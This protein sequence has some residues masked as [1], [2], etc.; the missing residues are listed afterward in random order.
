MGAK[1]TNEQQTPENH[2]IDIDLGGIPIRISNHTGADGSWKGLQLGLH[3][4]GLMV[5]DLD[6][7][8]AEMNPTDAEFIVEP[9]STRPGSRI[10]FVL[11]PDGVLM[12][13]IERK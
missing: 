2:I 9:R 7:V 1:V 4:L 8:V 5:D 10:A 6:K 11:T 3:H 13:L 12:E